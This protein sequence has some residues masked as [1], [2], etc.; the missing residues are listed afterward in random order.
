MVRKKSYVKVTLNRATDVRSPEIE[1]LALQVLRLSVR[2]CN[3]G[4]YTQSVE[5]T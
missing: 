5:Q 2:H 4:G 1:Q 3:Q